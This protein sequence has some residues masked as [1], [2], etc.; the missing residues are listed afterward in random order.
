MSGKCYYCDKEVEKRGIKR[1]LM[2][3]KSRKERIEL[4]P[5]EKIKNSNYFMIEISDKYRKS[6]YWLYI[7]CY[8][9]SKLS[10]IDKFL[11]GIWVECCGHLSEFVIHGIT[12]DCIED[13]DFKL[14]DF[15][16][17][18]EEQ[19]MNIK[20]KKVFDVGTKFNYSY[21]FGDTTQ[22]E[23]RV[24]D[25]FI[26]YTEDKNIEIMA[27]HN[28]PRYECTNCKNDA[29][30]FSYETGPV[31]SKCVGED[32][33]YMNEL[34]DLSSPRCGIC[35]Y[36]GEREDEEIYLPKVIEKQKNKHSESSAIKK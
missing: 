26:Y 9:E 16:V 28:N 6:D 31:C 11:R 35:G 25:S 8:K 15:Y 14:D 10:D 5:C 29:K 24:L 33:E 32:E 7:A 21:D 18:S 17:G 1:H 2:S 3:C 27:R 36:S 19:S 22:L 23:G 13:E 20:L 30:Y 4:L 34:G 12:Y